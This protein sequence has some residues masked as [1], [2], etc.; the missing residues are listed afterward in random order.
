MF[1]VLNEHSAQASAEEAINKCVEQVLDHNQQTTDVARAIAQVLL[2]A[3]N[4]QQ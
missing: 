3:A 2:K 1:A 4:G